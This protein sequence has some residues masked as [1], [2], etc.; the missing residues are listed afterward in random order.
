MMQYVYRQLIVQ[1]ISHLGDSICDQDAG[2]EGHTA[3]TVIGSL[4]LQ[5]TYRI[6]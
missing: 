3:V 5:S 2:T 1:F 4:P 6:Y